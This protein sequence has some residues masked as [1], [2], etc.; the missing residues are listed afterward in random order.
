MNRRRPQKPTV[1]DSLSHLLS[2]PVVWPVGVD[3]VVCVTA[4]TPSVFGDDVLVPCVGCGVTVR[5]R[6]YIPPHV[7]KLCP[8]CALRQV[9]GAAA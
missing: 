7:T 8:T 5:H 9:E 6:P 2:T 4:D 3:T 1:R